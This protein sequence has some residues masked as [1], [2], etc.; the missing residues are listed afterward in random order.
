MRALLLPLVAAALP[1][2][3]LAQS[4]DVTIR[5]DERGMY[6]VEGAFVVDAP[7]TVVWEVLTD[8]E[9]IDEFV[10]SIL[11][12]EVTER[13]PD[14]LLLQQEA[15]GKLFLFSKSIHLLLEVREEPEHTIAFRD[16]SGRSFESYSG[17]W[18]IEDA[19]DAVRVSYA[20]SAKPAFRQPPFVARRTMRDSVQRLLDEVRLEIE[21]RRFRGCRASSRRAGSRSSGRP[22]P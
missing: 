1:S 17:E 12:S 18:R 9:G 21:S 22:G 8:Y 2:V 10:S 3:A 11:R 13:R 16:V 14:G 19:G 6:R 15:V 7:R 5:D 20:L 4:A